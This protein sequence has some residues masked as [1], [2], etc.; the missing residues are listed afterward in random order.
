MHEHVSKCIERHRKPTGG[1]NKHGKH[2]IMQSGKGK[3]THEATRHPEMPP[4]WLHLNKA[5]WLSDVT[6]QGQAHGG[7]QTWH[8]LELERLTQA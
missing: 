6:T 4:K 3:G 1:I 2:S 8:S 5:S 7:R